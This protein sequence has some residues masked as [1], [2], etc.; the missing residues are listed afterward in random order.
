MR[1]T[2][3]I[4]RRNMLVQVLLM[5]IT[6]GLYSLYWYYVTLKE[7]HI[8]NN[9]DEGAGIWLVLLFIP[10]ANLFSWWHHSSE[11]ARFTS[12]KYPAILLFVLWIVFSP[13]VW[14]IVQY[15]LNNVTPNQPGLMAQGTAS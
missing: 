1:R 8:G 9:K 4:K 13:A 15:E 7:L 10:I 2:D 11:F 3:H 6:L 14:F 12:N 5:V